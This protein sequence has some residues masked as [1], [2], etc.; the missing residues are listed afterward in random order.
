MKRSERGQSLVEMALVL[1][2]VMLIMIGV[3]DL[4]RIVW[5][6]NNLSDG[7]RQGAR[8]AAVSPA[9]CAAID[10]AVRTATLG[11]D[12]A[13]FTVEYVAVNTLGVESTPYVLC[14]DGLPG[15]DLLPA[16]ARP[17]DRV[18]V[19]LQAGL[20]LGTPFVAAATG[21]STFDLDAASTMQV[22][23]VP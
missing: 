6:N 21:Q 11:Q 1:P 16:T 15:P 2:M 5:I 13:T 20:T 19:N 17:G 9:D 8:Q 10:E 7:A 23:Y 22:T 12:L 4:G 18:V 14:V 3:F